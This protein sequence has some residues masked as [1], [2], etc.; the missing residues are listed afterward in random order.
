MKSRERMKK[1]FNLGETQTC[2]VI[3]PIGKEGTEIYDK[4]KNILDY[5]IKPAVDK[6]GYELKVLRA[7]DVDRAG[8]FIKDILE[9]LLNSF[10]VIA[11]L[12]DQNPNV[13]YEL[14]VR[15]ALSARTILIAQDVSHIPSDL[16][17]YGSSEESVGNIRLYPDFSK[18]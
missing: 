5:V 13:F 11:D 18:A 3:S 14:G 16:R 12:T 8:S 9:L 17:E 15:H 2:F 7:D 4:F 10:I 6:S 1:G